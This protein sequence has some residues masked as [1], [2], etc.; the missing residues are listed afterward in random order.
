MLSGGFFLQP[1]NI[2][3][4]DAV[5]AWTVDILSRVINN[6][7]RGYATYVSFTDLSD[8]AAG[9]KCAADAVGPQSSKYCADGGVYYLNN[10]DRNGGHL[11]KP[12]G[13]DSLVDHGIT[14]A[15]ITKASAQAYRAKG[16]ITGTPA[17]G[18]YDD[19]ASQQV[20]ANIG[21]GNGRQLL[22]GLPGE[23]TLPVCAQGTN[24]WTWNYDSG[25]VGTGGN[26]PGNSMFP[27][28]CGPQGSE[29]AAFLAAANF[30][31]QNTYMQE[32]ALANGCTDILANQPLGRGNVVHNPNSPGWDGIAG[33]HPATLDLGN[34]VTIPYG[35]VCTQTQA[36]RKCTG[37]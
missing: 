11:D 37:P 24:Y 31:Y 15:N 9:S 36:G 5:D 13:Y 21:N 25:T 12:Y 22:G 16:I 1:T 14:P 30:N 2:S 10:Y 29:T 34:G 35:R 27:C 20:V 3:N 23:W 28:A 7:W 18:T 19:V 26:T 6:V 32:G 4:T 8:D 33:G 17:L